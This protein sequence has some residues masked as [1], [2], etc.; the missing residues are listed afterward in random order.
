VKVKMG[1]EEIYVK[2]LRIFKNIDLKKI[3]IIDNSVLSFAFQ[4]DNGIPILPFYDNKKDSEMLI[5]VNYLKHLS[6]VDDVLKENRKFLKMEYFFK[7]ANND[8]DDSEYEDTPES[9]SLTDCS[10]MNVLVLNPC[11]VMDP[12]ELNNSLEAN[13]YIKL[14][15]NGTSKLQKE[16]KTLILKE[17]EDFK[18]KFST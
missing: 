1:E 3:V 13:N 14:M 10:P 2:D 15:T 17:N 11:E 5:L 16:L 9:S 4:I 12:I 8:I 6:K 7:K 18:K